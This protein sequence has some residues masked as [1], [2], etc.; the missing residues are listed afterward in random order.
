MVRKLL[1][2][3]KLWPTTEISQ[4]AFTETSST[5]KRTRQSVTIREKSGFKELHDLYKPLDAHN[6]NRI[7]RLKESIELFEKLQRAA[8]NYVLNVNELAR[9]YLLKARYR[10]DKENFFNSFRAESTHVVDNDL[11]QYSKNC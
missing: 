10:E 8:M 2:S 4:N 5:G 7:L 3:L 6:D 11:W 1:S 9:D